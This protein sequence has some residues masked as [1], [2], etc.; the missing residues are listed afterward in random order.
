M[1]QIILFLEILGGTA[2]VSVF[3]AMVICALITSKK[4]DE[5]EQ[6]SYLDYRGKEILKKINGR[7]VR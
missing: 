4:R 5:Y 2:I 1:D 7:K 3:I 6:D